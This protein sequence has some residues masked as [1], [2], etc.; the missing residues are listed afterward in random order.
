MRGS[1]LLLLAGCLAFA[2]CSAPLAATP[3]ASVRATDH[4][5]RALTSHHSSWFAWSQFHPS[6]SLWAPLDST[7]RPSGGRT[8]ADERSGPPGPLL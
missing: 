2:G 4:Q 8:S 6:T 3:T 5:G 7:G 1:G